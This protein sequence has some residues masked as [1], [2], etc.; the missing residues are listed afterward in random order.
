MSPVQNQNDTYGACSYRN[1]TS[2]S[3]DIRPPARVY[4]PIAMTGAQ[5]E[6]RVLVL[7]EGE[8]KRAEV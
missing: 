5:A 4:D 1:W 7:R 6:W 8:G 3:L 2:S